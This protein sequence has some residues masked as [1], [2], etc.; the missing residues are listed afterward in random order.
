MPKIA[1][2]KKK[3]MEQ[4]LVGP[5]SPKYVNK[6]NQNQQKSPTLSIAN[7]RYM[8]ESLQAQLR[9]AE[10]L[11]RLYTCS[12]SLNFQGFVVVWYT[13]QLWQKKTDKAF[14]DNCKFNTNLY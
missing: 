13:A 10:P 6:P 5:F 2:W 11:H 7:Y 8:T 3:H 12:L 4:D 9:A 14:S 1:Y